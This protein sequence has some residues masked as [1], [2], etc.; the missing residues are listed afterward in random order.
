MV[1]T[2]ESAGEST[3]CND[4]AARATMKWTASAISM[5]RQ[6]SRLFFVSYD[7]SVMKFYDPL[8]SITRFPIIYIKRNA[9]PLLENDD[10]PGSGPH[11]RY[12]PT[13][14]IIIIGKGCPRR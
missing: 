14:V 7:S 10:R 8:E 4:L 3:G 13:G 2:I 11:D 9:K 5:T 6:T 1:F 12:N